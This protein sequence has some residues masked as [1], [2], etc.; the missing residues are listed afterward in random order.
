MSIVLR[1]VFAMVLVV[2]IPFFLISSAFAESE[3][4]S[5]KSSV[6][7]EKKSPD[8]KSFMKINGVKRCFPQAKGEPGGR[9]LASFSSV[10]PGEFKITPADRY[11]IPPEFTGS[12]APESAPKDGAEVKD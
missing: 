5:A 12:V 7:Q 8:C 4:S 10:P 2:L 1:L 11:G 9:P 6:A 3:N